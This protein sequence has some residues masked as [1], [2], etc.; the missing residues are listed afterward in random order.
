MMEVSKNGCHY[1]FQW[2]SKLACSICLNTQVSTF[3]SNCDA[4]N[5][6][7]S[8]KAAERCMIYPEPGYLFGDLTFKAIPAVNM[9]EAASPFVEVF[10]TLE[11]CQLK[12]DFFMHPVIKAFLILVSVLWFTIIFVIL[13]IFF[14]YRNLKT[15]Y[16]RLGEE[17]GESPSQ[18]G[19]IEMQTRS[20]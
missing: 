14:K 8:M 17:G 4:G 6:T 19:E 3:K 2:I 10:T 20:N 18:G 1:Q 9:S 5:R 12:D 13:C 16:S 7:V 15:R 11:Q